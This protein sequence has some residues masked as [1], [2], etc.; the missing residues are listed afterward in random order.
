MTAAAAAV[1]AVAVAASV[2]GGRQVA[3]CPCWLDGCVICGGKN[4]LVVLAAV[5][6]SGDRGWFVYSYLC[7]I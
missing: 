1:A 6:M 3:L 2:A 4:V 7:I 5:V